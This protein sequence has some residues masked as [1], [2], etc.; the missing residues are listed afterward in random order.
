[1]NLLQHKRRC[2]PVGAIAIISLSVTACLGQ[3]RDNVWAEH[4]PASTASIDH[5]SWQSVL[6]TYLVT[7]DS[8]GVHLFEYGALQANTADRE[9]LNGY[10]DYLQQ[11]HPREYTRDEQ[12]AYW[13][14]LYN[15]LTVRVVVDAY[16]VSS[17]LQI[18]DGEAPGTGP[19][20]DVRATIAG[21]PL[22]LD[23]IEHDILRPVWKDNR[24]HYA[25][26]CASMGCPDLAAETFSADN[27]ER[28]LEEC[29]VA[30]INHPRGVELLDEA[31]GVMSSI[32]AWYM[33]DF[34]DTEQGVIEHMLQYAKGDLAD[35]L[36]NFEGSL[37]HEYDWNLNVPADK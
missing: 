30:F 9:R 17:V 25:V 2:A 27:L 16:P 12:M 14:N 10:L 36:A 34:G 33:E 22:T 20:K 1:M 26:N 37:D 21:N 7:N 35:Q 3:D 13:I 15:A 19:W 6:D 8:S 32:Y 24:I 18:H 4:D 31:F 23:N 28:L 29:A 5:S 11:L